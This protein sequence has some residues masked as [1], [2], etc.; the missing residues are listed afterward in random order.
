M[1]NQVACIV[2]S[3]LSVSSFCFAQNLLLTPSFE[4]KNGP[5]NGHMWSR[6]PG[7]GIGNWTV[8]GDGVDWLGSGGSGNPTTLF[9]NQLV[10]LRSNY[11]NYEGAGGV[12]QTVEVIPGSNYLL[13]VWARGWTMTL[14]I[15]LIGNDESIQFGTTTKW[16]KYEVL[17]QPT[18]SPLNISIEAEESNANIV[19]AGPYIDNVELLLVEPNVLT[20]DINGEADFINIQA[21]IAASSDG[22]EIVVMPGTYADSGSLDTMGK[23]IWLHSSNGP[24]ETFIDGEGSRRVMKCVNGETKATVIEGFTIMDGWADN[25]AGGL[26]IRNSSPSIRNCVINNNSAFRS[27]GGV[28]IDAANP[29]F[30]DCIISNNNTGTGTADDDGGGVYCNNGN[31]TFTNCNF[32]DNLSEDHGGGIKSSSSTIT[33]SNCNITGNTSNNGGGVYSNDSNLTFTNNCSI[34]SNI[35]GGISSENNGSILL[36]TCTISLNSATDG[37]GACFDGAEKVTIQNCA[38]IQ[39]R[40]DMGGATHGGAI[41]LDGSN[42][43]VENSVFYLNYCDDDAG[44]VYLD[45]SSS[46]FTNCLFDS[47]SAYADGG[48]IRTVS[49]SSATFDNCIFTQNKTKNS[50]GRGGAIQNNGATVSISECEFN[51]NESTE[52]GAVHNNSGSFTLDSSIFCENIPDNDAGGGFRELPEGNTV[53]DVCP[54]KCDLSG[55][56][57]VEVN[58]IVEIIIHW[59]C[60]DC[61]EEDIDGDGIVDF[62]DLYGVIDAWDYIISDWGACE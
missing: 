31:V 22:D 17:L 26:L 18:V 5:P 51:M 33:F 59:G 3:V 38:F 40:S 49:T 6:G 28:M 61:L 54:C 12:S 56:G 15:T 23:A 42:A 37:A 62:S 14:P 36:D 35:G 9:G 55:D 10:R 13:S 57:I 44:A 34:S 7:T 48:A 24:D 47:N 20:V 29:T 43:L 8:T 19:Y 50:S 27:G 58:D 45:S 25:E 53:F 60:L 11:W 52:G 1:K 46:T 21:A 30:T 41:M 4:D 39:N 2:L 16:T 32:V